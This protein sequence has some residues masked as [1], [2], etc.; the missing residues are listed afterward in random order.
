[1]AGAKGCGGPSIAITYST[2][3]IN[4]SLID[5]QTLYFINAQKIFNTEYGIISDCMVVEP[6]TS[7]T[8]INSLC[9]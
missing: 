5:A 2:K 8:C 4:T 9:Q 6:P 3:N 1:M 7:M